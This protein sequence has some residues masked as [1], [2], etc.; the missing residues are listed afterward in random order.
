M[1]IFPPPPLP[2][3]PRM[4]C[5][6]CSLSS[7]H[8]LTGLPTWC[9]ASGI[10]HG[11]WCGTKSMKSALLMS[12]HITPVKNSLHKQPP[13]SNILFLKYMS[14]LFSMKIFIYFLYFLYFLSFV[15]TSMTS[16]LSAQ[17]L[18]FNPLVS[19]MVLIK[20]LTL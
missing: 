4:T 5:L 19:K 12:P 7:A 20:L 3:P 2:H 6:T 10:S 1:F 15:T 14:L 17:P 11:S 18:Q 16:Q 13:S 8:L 9:Q